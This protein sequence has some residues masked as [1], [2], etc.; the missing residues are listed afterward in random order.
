VLGGTAFFSWW[1]IDF[2]LL[3]VNDTVRVGGID[4]DRVLSFG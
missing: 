2:V 3:L 1:T 4:Y